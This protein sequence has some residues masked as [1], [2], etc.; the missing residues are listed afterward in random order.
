M[1]AVAPTKMAPFV[2]STANKLVGR[3]SKSGYG[4]KVVFR[5]RELQTKWTKDAQPDEINKVL[6]MTDLLGEDLLNLTRFRFDGY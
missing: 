1:S 4:L 6:V 5:H 2:S 3:R